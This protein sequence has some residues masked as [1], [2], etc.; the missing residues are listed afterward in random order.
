M[1]QDPYNDLGVALRGASPWSLAVSALGCI[2]R[3]SSVLLVAGAVNPDVT[4]FSEDSLA[5]LGQSREISMVLEVVVS[6]QQELAIYS[7]D[8]ETGELSE[9]TDRAELLALASETVLRASRNTDFESIWE[10]VNF[11]CSF[12]G[13]IAQHLDGMR[14]STV[15][16][17]NEGWPSQYDDIAPLPAR[18]LSTQ[19]EIIQLA[20]R[21]DGEA[22]NRISNLSISMRNA[23][24]PIALEAI[25][26]AAQVE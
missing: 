7:A 24:F 6:R 11:C 14:L 5:R 4:L 23:L 10:W 9:E 26:G 13:D 18:E 20:D 16:S 3:A 1:P 25:G 2:H 12:T 17:F 22:I 19:L 15:D 21:A 8:P